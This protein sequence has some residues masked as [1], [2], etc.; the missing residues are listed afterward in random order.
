[1]FGVKPNQDR[2]P[3]LPGVITGEMVVRAWEGGRT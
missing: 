2:T 3:N 1:M